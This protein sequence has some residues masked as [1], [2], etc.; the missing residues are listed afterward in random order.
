M[1]DALNSQDAWIE[2]IQRVIVP[3]VARH[4]AGVGLRLI[5]GSR[6]YLLDR[7]S[8]FSRDLDYDTSEEL[9]VK[10]AAVLRVLQT[11]LVPDL[12]ERFGVETLVAPLEGKDASPSVHELQVAFRP[13]G[14]ERP[15]VVSVQIL[16]IV[17][18][19]GQEN[20]LFE[21]TMVPTVSDADLVESKVIAIFNRIH[22]A[23]RDLVD[24]FLF[25]HGLRPD[26]AGRMQAKLARLGIGADLVARQLADFREHP[27][28]HAKGIGQIVREEVEPIQARRLEESGGGRAIL[29]AVRAILEHR[30]RLGGGAP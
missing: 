10:Q 23:H 3:L 14:W 18:L 25:Q 13:E 26:S 12:A 9:A 7:S 22:L 4:P 28:F 24:L 16:S 21:G 15:V 11:K 30:L 1:K 27:D 29:E 20:R 2:A 17:S 5:G 19:D 6:F 8:R